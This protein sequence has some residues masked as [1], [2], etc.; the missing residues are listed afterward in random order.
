MFVT[1]CVGERKRVRGFVTDKINLRIRNRQAH[2]LISINCHSEMEK[3]LYQY[4]PT[5]LDSYISQGITSEY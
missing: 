4:F 1:V 3:P 5:L 2:F